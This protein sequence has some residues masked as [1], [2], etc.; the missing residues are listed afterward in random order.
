MSA[1]FAV[2]LAGVNLAIEDTR[3]NERGDYI[4]ADDADSCEALTIPAELGGLRLD[5]ALA[6][7]FPEHSRSRL[8]GWLKDGFI[9]VDGGQPDA[10]RKVWGGECI[11]V[12]AP[13]PPEVAAHLPEDIALAVVFEDADL[14]VIDKPAGLVVHPGSGNWSGTLLNALLHHDPALAAVPRAGIVHRLDKDT[15]GLMVVAKT[16]AA[17]TELVRQ[18]QARTVK[19]HYR[20]L[21]QGELTAGGTVDAPI[22]RHPAQR[23]RMAVAGN[24]RPAITHY[25]IAER[26]TGCTLLECRLET[27]RTHQI[28]VHMAHIGHPLAGDPVYAPRRCGNALLDAFPRQALHAFRLGLMHPRSGQAMS[29]EV[30]LA[31]DLA[32]LLD[33]LRGGA[34]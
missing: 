4:P 15:S 17:Q 2:K 29:W 13:P 32:Q 31:A 6:R 19:R 9:R 22:G 10:R 8:Q 25:L 33:G 26:F 24:G 28:R 23:T 12:D 3:V 21:V 11:E 7:L 14:L 16:L 34:R 18:L 27:G 20:A 5:Q 1:A 30:P